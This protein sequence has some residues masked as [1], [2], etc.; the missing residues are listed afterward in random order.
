MKYI[1]ILSLTLV[2]HTHCFAQTDSSS[3]INQPL[4]K[5]FYK[6]YQEYLDNN[7]SITA[8][9]TTELYRASKRDTTIIAGTYKL[10]SGTVKANKIWGFC[11]GKSVFIRYKVLIGNNYWKAQVLGPHP[12]FLYKEKMILAAGPPIMAIA[13]AVTTAALPAG[14]EIM[15][16][17]GPGRPKYVWKGTMKKILSDQ[18]A[19]LEAFKK[20]VKVISDKYRVKYLKLYSEAA[21][22]N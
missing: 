13:T 17:T 14:F 3:T 12:Y 9:F 8:D 6:T 7:P 4:K 5:G 11:D 16:V 15:A 18:P 10:H 20:E 1:K 21:A 2:L 22:E 19:L